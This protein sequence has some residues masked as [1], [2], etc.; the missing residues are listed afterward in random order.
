MTMISAI[1]AG[2]DIRAMAAFWVAAETADFHWEARRE[3]RW[4][5]SY[6]SLDPYE[7][8][9]DRVAILGSLNGKWFAGVAIVDGNGAVHDL[10]RCDQFERAEVA[11]LAFQ[12]LR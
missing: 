4:L 11:G 3:E 5:G 7:E 10:V 1:K 2:S 9:L 8:E 6:E 12:R